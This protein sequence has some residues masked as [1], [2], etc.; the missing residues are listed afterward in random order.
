MATRP[1]TAAL[2][3]LA[4]AT[5]L[6]TG[7][8]GDDGQTDHNPW[9]NTG[10]PYTGDSGTASFDGERQALIPKAGGGKGGGSG[11]GGGSKSEDLKFG[12]GGSSGSRSSSA[13]SAFRNSTVTGSRTFTS[14]GTT[15]AVAQRANFPLRSRSTQA[16]NRRP[17]TRECT[18]V[19]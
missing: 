18:T 8:S 14:D 6:L 7:R 16:Q 9:G 15:Y 10:K 1:A 13:S 12:S 5:T 19:P 11:S 17:T 4:L 3:N 2:A